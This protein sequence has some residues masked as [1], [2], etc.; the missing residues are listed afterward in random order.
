V[1]YPSRIDPETIGS[2]GLAVV[3]QAGWG[4][5]S[6]R[7]VAKKLEVTPN[8]LYRHID[9]HA[10]L[11][12]EI[13]ASAAH[14]LCAEIT[15][16]QSSADDGDG[17]SAVVDIA[18]RYVEFAM[19]RPHAY[20][21]FTAAKPDLDHPAIGRWL[22]LWALVH[23]VVAGAVP[24]S[25]DAAAFAL[26]ALIHGRISL[27]AGPARMAEPTAGLAEAVRAL[28]VGYREAG[29][30]ESPLPAELRSDQVGQHKLAEG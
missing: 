22:E 20:Q 11:V 3:E 5:W 9:G 15:A 17:T 1:P 21:A 30:V 14:Q 12:V 26:W 18:Y 24:A 10:G 27:A 29:S 23:Q 6:L 13:G 28:I 2:V 4:H 25:T 19:T 8:A 16:A 7:D